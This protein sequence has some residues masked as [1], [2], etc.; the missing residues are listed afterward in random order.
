MNRGH[1]RRAAL[2]GMFGE[3]CGRAFES[4]ADGGLRA[5][6]LCHNGM[7]DYRTSASVDSGLHLRGKCREK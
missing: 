5:T 3:V 4:L 6:Q 7:L 2:V 1:V